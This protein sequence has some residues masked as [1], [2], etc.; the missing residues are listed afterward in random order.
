MA[1]ECPFEIH[2]DSVEKLKRFQ[3]TELPG[4]SSSIRPFPKEGVSVV[5]VN[6]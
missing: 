5:H 4:P 2:Y 6:F 1:E 3:I